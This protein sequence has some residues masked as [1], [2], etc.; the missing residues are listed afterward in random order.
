MPTIFRQVLLMSSTL[1]IALALASS[2]NNI[3]TSTDIVAE[4]LNSLVEHGSVYLFLR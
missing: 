4:V 2:N 3:F 1:Y